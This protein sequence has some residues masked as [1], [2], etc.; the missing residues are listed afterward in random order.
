MA[1]KQTLRRFHR[2]REAHYALEREKE[3]QRRQ[4]RLKGFKP[5]SVREMAAGVLGLSPGQSRD[6]VDAESLAA[7]MNRAERRARR[8]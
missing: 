6:E 4:A 2:E 1:S 3:L 5:A 7:G 8:G